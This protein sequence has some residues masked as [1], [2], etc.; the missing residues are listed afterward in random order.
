MVEGRS[1]E[2]RIGH[3]DESVRALAATAEGMSQNAL[4][5]APGPD[6]WSVMKVLAHAVELLPYWAHQAS[7][8]ASR[9]E[10][11]QPFGR[12]HDDPDRIA[13]VEDHGAD[14]LRQ[15]LP[16]LEASLREAVA[17]LRSIPPDAWSKTALHARR[18]EM[19]VADIVDQ[20]M[21]QHMDEHVAQARQIAAA[22][23]AA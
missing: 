2:E 3:L 11:N 12:T 14:P 22:V 19:S 10:R 15:M 7:E 23:G 1:V 21:V 16:K 13:A 18:G 8:V 17:T 4:Y 5:R 6:D 9:A 20:F